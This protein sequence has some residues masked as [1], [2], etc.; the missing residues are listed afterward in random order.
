[1]GLGAVRQGAQDAIP[2][3]QGWTRG[4]L[5]YLR[6]R[7]G[8]ERLTPSNPASPRVTRSSMNAGPCGE[9]GWL[10]STDESTT[11]QAA[12]AAPAKSSKESRTFTI[13]LGSTGC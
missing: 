6:G 8:L 10:F 9:S 13:P 2:A 12:A 3:A 7:T 11:V 4:H 5:P 1:M